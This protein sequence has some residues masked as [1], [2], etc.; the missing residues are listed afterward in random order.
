MMN[1]NVSRTH[2]ESRSGLVF[3][4]CFQARGHIPQEREIRYVRCSNQTK[5]LLDYKS[6]DYQDGWRFLVLSAEEQLY[7]KMKVESRIFYGYLQLVK[8]DIDFRGHCVGHGSLS[9]VLLFK[10]AVEVIET[11]LEMERMHNHG[12]NSFQHP[13]GT[14]QPSYQWRTGGMW[15]H[16]LLICV[17]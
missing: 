5:L 11:V 1:Q 16:Y 10:I 8:F 12:E 14:E 17:I 3:G 13:C 9:V 6:L 4:R 15:V 7:S 2:Y